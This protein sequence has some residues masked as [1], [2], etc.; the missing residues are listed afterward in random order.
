MKGAR[1]MHPERMKFAAPIIVVMLGVSWLLD[2]W[3]VATGVNWVLTVGL[4]TTGVCV[5]VVGGIDK[6]T[7]VMGPFLIAVSAGRFLSQIGRLAECVEKPIYVIVLGCLLLLAQ[8]PKIPTPSILKRE[9]WRD[10]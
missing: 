5:L 9:S 3:D 6:L 1:V 4:A 8:V 7:V 2:T 10:E